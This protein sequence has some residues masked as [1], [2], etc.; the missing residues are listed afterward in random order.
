[1]ADACAELS[2]LPFV[3]SPANTNTRGLTGQ[4]K[5]QVVRPRTPLRLSMF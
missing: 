1:M 4:S 5:C 3:C 2:S